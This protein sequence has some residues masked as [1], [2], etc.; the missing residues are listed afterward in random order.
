VFNDRIAQ[1]EKLVKEDQQKLY[2]LF[3]KPCNERSDQEVAQV[4]SI[5]A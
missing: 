2:L 1:L 4:S 3:Q 5:F